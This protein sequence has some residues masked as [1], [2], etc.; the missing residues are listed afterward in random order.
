VPV[1][2]LGRWLLG[3]AALPGV[4]IARGAWPDRSVRSA[5]LRRARSRAMRRPYLSSHLL[6]RVVVV[7]IGADSHKRTHTVVALDEVGRRLGELTVAA[8]TDGHLKL[9]AWSAQWDQVGFALEDCRHLTRRLERDLLGAGARVVRVPT[10][11]MAGA[12]RGGREPGKSDPIDAEAVAIA[13]LRHDGL[14]VAE[15]DGPARELRCWSTIVVTSSP[16]APASRADCAG[17]CTNSTPLS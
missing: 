3:D 1:P 7:M 14:P 15:L 13:A 6:E 12:R 4:R 16:S 10:R 17:T 8:T 5:R 9:L 11:L 2:D